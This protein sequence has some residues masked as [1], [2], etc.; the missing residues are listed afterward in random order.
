MMVVACGPADTVVSQGISVNN[1]SL[2]LQTTWLDVLLNNIII[3]QSPYN[4][5]FH[6]ASF[7]GISEFELKVNNALET[8]M[9]PLLT[10]SGGPNQGTLFYGEYSWHPPA[11]G[12]YLLEVSAY[13]S[14]GQVGNTA[15]AYVTVV[16][17]L[18]AE[19]P[20]DELPGED[21][22]EPADALPG[23]DAQEPAEPLTPMFDTNVFYY[24]GSCS[25]SQINA[26]I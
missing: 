11:P 24:G 9:A 3:P 18:Q 8:A 1:L 20:P 13:S 17:E 26:E 25:P 15:T 19:P 10:G 14:D 2:S 22:E 6:A 7:T 5:V 12:L 16:A 21:A 4:V 23:E